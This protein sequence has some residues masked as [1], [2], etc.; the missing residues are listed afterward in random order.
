MSEKQEIKLQQPHV[1]E[2]TELGDHY[3]CEYVYFELS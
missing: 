1:L 2:Q 3:S